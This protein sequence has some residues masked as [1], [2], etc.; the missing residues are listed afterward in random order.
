V[1]CTYDRCD[2]T[3]GCLSDLVPDESHDCGSFN[4]GRMGIRDS[5]SPEADVLK[6]MLLLHGGE[7]GDPSDSTAYALCLFDHVGGEGVLVDQIEIPAGAPWLSKGGGFAYLDPAGSVE[8]VK[9]VTVKSDSEGQNTKL[10]LNASGANM[11]LPAPYDGD[12][13]LA[14]EPQ[15]IVQ[16]ENSA[17]ACWSTAFDP[18]L[19]RVVNKPSRVAVKRP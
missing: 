17:G 2:A 11:T 18:N 10:V 16:V 13:Y 7:I 15:V 1:F 8:G 19:G 3:A 14:L 6:L 9:K 4:M 12:G 5:A